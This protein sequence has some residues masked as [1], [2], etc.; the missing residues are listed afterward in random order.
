MCRGGGAEDVEVAG[1][2]LHAAR[3]AGEGIGGAG[4]S[5]CV[6]ERALSGAV[7]FYG[8]GCDGGGV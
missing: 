3:F 5:V 6:G 1:Q 4:D 8:G 7:E 2:F